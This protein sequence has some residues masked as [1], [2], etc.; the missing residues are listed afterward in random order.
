M[1]RIGNL[2]IP[3]ARVFTKADKISRLILNKNLAAHDKA[4]LEAWESL[5]PTFVTSAKSGSGREEILSFVE[6]TITL[7]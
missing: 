5:P 3:F 6:N 1:E 7:F 4:M 2:G